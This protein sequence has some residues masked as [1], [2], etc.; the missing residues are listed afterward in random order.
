MEKREREKEPKLS[1]S[2]SAKMS[3][4]TTEKMATMIPITPKALI[5]AGAGRTQR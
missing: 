2:R 5:T 1:G 3:K 4:A